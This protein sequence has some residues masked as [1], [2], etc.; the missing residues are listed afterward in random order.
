MDK[1]NLNEIKVILESAYQ[2]VLKEAPKVL[3]PNKK[4][5]KEPK[6]T[7]DNADSLKSKGVNSKTIG[8]LNTAMTEWKKI[9]DAIK[10]QTAEF[11]KK[12]EQDVKLGLGK[13]QEVESILKKL[14]I[15]AYEVN[16]IVA[17]MTKEFNRDI[18]KYEAIYTEAL[19]KVNDDAKR[20]LQRLY[21]KNKTVSKVPSKLKMET[22]KIN[23]LIKMIEA[24]SGKKVAFLNEGVGEWIKAVVLS[25][26]DLLG[27]FSN[28]VN[29]LKG[30]V[31]R[32]G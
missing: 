5:P 27:V 16:Q 8:T 4:A 29:R 1:K 12:I 13:F 7:A 9:N 3:P 14:N 22:K 24:K 11:N 17:K 15:D 10:K 28:S 23:A 31:D 26:K 25:I 6:P 19:E 18:V 32:N 2:A 30:L 21:K 20:I